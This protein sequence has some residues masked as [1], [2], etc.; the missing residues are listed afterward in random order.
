MRDESAPPIDRRHIDVRTMSLAQ[1]QKLAERGSRRAR[2]ELEARMRAP[3]PVLL[4]A[5]VPADRT[6]PSA[7]SR[8]PPTLTARADPPPQATAA[9]AAAPAPGA[10]PAGQGV[11]V[12]ADALAQQLHLIARQDEAHARAAG[13]PR[14]VG[15]VLTAWG[16]LLLLGGLLMLGRGGAALYYLFCGLGAAAVGALLMRRSRWALALHGA[17]LPLALGWAWAGAG[18]HSLPLSVVQAGPLLIPALWMAL[19]QVRE[20]LE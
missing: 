10:V 17:L 1:L 14:L 5:S 9:G 16:V 13:P 7:P 3:G 12:S 4:P 11:P 18:R 2:A 8:H 6:A 20:A 19:R 15:L